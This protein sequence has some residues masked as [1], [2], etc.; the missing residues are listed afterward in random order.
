MYTRRRLLATA[1]AAGLVPLTGCS[2][3]E[4]HPI[5]FIN[6]LDTNL[7][8][9]LEVVQADDA[10]REGSPAESTVQERWRWLFWL[11]AGKSRGEDGP[12]RHD[13]QY[14]VRAFAEEKKGTAWV[15]G[16]ETLEIRITEGG[17]QMVA[18]HE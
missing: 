2:A 11:K 8:I 14:Y 1:G 5:E 18:Y 3:S 12:W 7:K 13:G 15:T 4:W 17:I 16:S 10:S 6:E 9:R